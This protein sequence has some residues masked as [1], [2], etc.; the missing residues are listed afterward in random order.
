MRTLCDRFGISD[1]ALKKTCARFDIPTPERGYWAKFEAGKK[2][3]QIPFPPRGPG[4]SDKVVI[5]G[6]GHHYGYFN[7]AEYFESLPPPPE[8]SES[9][10]DL[11]ERITR[12]IGKVV[13]QRNPSSWHPSLERFL[14]EDNRRRE[15]YLASRYA[16][17][18]PLFDT[19]LEQRRLRTLNSLFIA[20]AKMH[21]KP[22]IRGR[23]AREISISFQMNHVGISLDRPKQVNRRGYVIETS[24]NSASNKLCL[25]I[26]QRLGSDK[27]RNSWKDSDGSNL[28]SRM[29][30]IAIEIVMAAE[31]QYRENAVSHYEWRIKRKAEIEEEK[32]QKQIA[33]ERAERERQERLKQ[34][35]IDRLL[36]DAETFQKAVVIRSYVG[37]IRSKLSVDQSLAPDIVE[38]WSDWALAQADRIDPSRNGT[39]LK[40]MDDQE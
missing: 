17:D 20:T 11:R 4:M 37:A 19:P 9:L 35:R 40:A 29:T 33:A 6:G 15:K 8:F 24:A 18:A 21:G 39:F 14:N 13:V 7:D 26:P 16:W 22:S 3:N 36:K 1:V 34:A 23:E 27:E 5:G 25:S 28:E 31:I 32:R 38:R 12:T 30:E 2:T 10:E